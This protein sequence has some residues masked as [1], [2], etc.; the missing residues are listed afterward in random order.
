M[1]NIENTICL[2]DDGEILLQLK[3]KAKDTLSKSTGI[4]WNKMAQFL[5]EN[6]EFNE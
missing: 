4:K 1:K 2:N 5:N 3:P 6:P